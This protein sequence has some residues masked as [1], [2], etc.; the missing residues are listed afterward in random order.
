INN[1][2]YANHG[3]AVQSVN[4]YQVALVNN[5]IANN[6]HVLP[7]SGTEADAYLI[8]NDPN[9]GGPINLLVLNNIV[10]NNENCGLFYHNAGSVTTSHN[11]LYMNA[12]GAADYCEG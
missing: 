2:V 3:S 8:W 6:V 1:I 10:A 4:A 11:L 7:N 9:Y 5:T 12:G